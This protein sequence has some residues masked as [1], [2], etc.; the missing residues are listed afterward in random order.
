M[1][2]M[3]VY[4][5]KEEIKS[6]F[7]VFEPTLN[8]NIRFYVPKGNSLI[9]PSKPRFYVAGKVFYPESELEYFTLSGFEM[10]MKRIGK[11]IQI[12]FKK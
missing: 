11:I 5:N 2:E 8:K 10:V 4:Y 6:V 3:F 1:Y 9:T 12:G 7:D